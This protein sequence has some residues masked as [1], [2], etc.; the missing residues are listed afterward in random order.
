MRLLVLQLKRIGDTVLTAPALALLRE[1]LPGAEIHLVLHGPC[2]QLAPLLPGIAR[3]HTWQPGRANVGILRTIRSARFD[4]VLDLTSTDR[5][6][7]LAGLSRARTRVAWA[8][9]REERWWRK[10][11]ATHGIVA[12]VRGLTTVDFHL[13]LTNG[14]LKTLGLPSPSLPPPPYLDLGAAQAPAGLP[15]RFLLIHPGSARPEKMWPAAS[16][17]ETIR[18][19][20]TRHPIPV[21]L[22]GGSDPSELRDIAE[23]TAATGAISYAGTLDLAASA[24]VIGRAALALTVDSA[25]MHLAAQFGIPQVALFGPTNPYHW[26]PRHPRARVLL[27]AAPEAAATTLTPHQTPAPVTDILPTHLAREAAALLGS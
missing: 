9:A 21:V 22:T 5:S 24:A 11:A 18:L 7:L 15:G 1:A 16:W 13:A 23:I 25:A 6:F 17:I 10:H 27:A 14:L 3:T 20:Q 12:S 4:A 19:I 26:A 2:G 8:R